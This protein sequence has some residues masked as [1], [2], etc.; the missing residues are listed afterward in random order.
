M[1]I[2]G[3]SLTIGNA[4]STGAFEIGNGVSTRGG[5]L[6][7]T[8]G[9]LTYL[10][11]DGLLL[12][13]LSGSVNGANIS[14]GT[15]TLTGVTL[16][17]VN[18][19]GATSSLTLSGGAT[20]Y[21]GG[22]GLV[23][24]QPSATAYAALGTATVGAIT[25]W[26]SSVPITLTNTVTFQAADSGGTAHNISLNGILSGTGA[27]VKTGGGTFT[28]SG[29]NTY[30]GTTTVSSGTLLANNK[31]GSATGTNTVTVISGGT[32]GGTGTIFGKVVWQP[33]AMA[34]F[35]NSS[36]LTV[37]NS[38]TLN[39]NTVTVNISGGTPL[40]AGSYTLMNY[41]ATGSSG[42]FNATPVITGAGLA[43]ADTATI[44]TSGGT[45]S[46]VVNKTTPVL[47]TAPTASAI[48]YG[49]ALSASTLSGGVV[50]NLSGTVV[51]GTF[52]FTSPSTVP[53]VGTAGESV[54][55]TPTDT[56]GYNMVSLNVSVTVNP[57]VTNPQFNPITL[58]ANGLVL[59]G[60]GGVTNGTYYV[61]GTT[62]LALP[63]NQWTPLL[64]NQFDN[65]GNFNFT[66]PLDPNLSQ[67]FYIL[68]V[69]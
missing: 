29:T 16:N 56:T 60:T 31:G 67:D 12:N 23:I 53:G 13:I 25:N 32:L 2:N 35:T 5:W 22:T 18:V 50:T 37:A 55:F 61:L 1:N 57:L 15:A 19:A 63:L 21:L 34:L 28:L 4:S 14:G 9:S 59:S 39:N 44:I 8:G 36:P 30:A 24:N 17:Q 54:T 69:P 43:A 40:A 52:A 46:L 45:V 38:V 11:T 26:S 6:T 47:E 51:S 68:Q 66:N 58:G 42:S 10:G 64:T 33:G 48:T 49:Q 7:M 41:T 65:N 62:N 20:L 3:G 27:L